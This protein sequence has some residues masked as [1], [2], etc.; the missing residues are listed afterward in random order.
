MHLG[1]NRR[2]VPLTNLFISSYYYYI[3]I[4]EKHTSCKA[5]KLKTRRLSLCSSA[6]KLVK[7]T[8]SYKFMVIFG[9]RITKF[10]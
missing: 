2:W 5:F 4:P 3:I 6:R 8:F 7:Q 10:D 9:K 1:G